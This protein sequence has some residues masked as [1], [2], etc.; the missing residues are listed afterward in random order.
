MTILL[1]DPRV[2][3]VPVREEGVPLV[4]LAAAFGPAEALVRADLADRLRLAQQA[5]PIR[6]RLRVIEGH[7]SI[8]DQ[9]AI[10]VRYRAELRIAHPG[11][12]DAE[13]HEL[14]SRFVS[15]VD[16]A[17]HVAGAAVDLTLTTADGDELD[18][19]TVVDATPEQSDGACYFAAGNISAAARENRAL[20]ARAL[21]GAG[22][23]N[24]PTEWWH[25]SYGDRYWALMTGA[26]AALHGPVRETSP[27]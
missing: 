22:L 4:R 7:R 3:A 11:A 15:P 20:L 19:G 24:Y 26:P 13:L 14:T 25:W 10:I 23:V 27:R 17:P 18:M 6:V 16:V 12:G 2:A 8:A 5:L 1:C 21:G 9:E